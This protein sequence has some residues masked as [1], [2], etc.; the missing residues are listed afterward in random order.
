M[1]RIIRVRIML[2]IRFRIIFYIFLKNIYLMRNLGKKK[3]AEAGYSFVCF[4]TVLTMALFLM[5]YLLTVKLD[6][7]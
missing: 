2:S 6:L 1:D 7:L 4:I 3:P 5:R